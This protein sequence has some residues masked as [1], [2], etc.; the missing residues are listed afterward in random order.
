MK[1][2]FFPAERPLDGRCPACGT[3]L[4]FVTVVELVD[5]ALPARPENLREAPRWMCR[6]CWRVEVA[7]S[8]GV[9]PMAAAG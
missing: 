1:R 2:L 9:D 5:T 8:A 7:A 4:V 3:T 6:A